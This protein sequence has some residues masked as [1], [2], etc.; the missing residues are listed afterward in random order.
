MLMNIATFIS[1]LIIVE[2]DGNVNAVGDD[3]DNIGCLQIHHNVVEDVNNIFG[4]DFTLDD[5]YDMQMS[6]V[7]CNLYLSYWGAKYEEN[8]GFT[9][10]PEV[11]AR[12]WN[13]GP[14]G[15]NKVSTKKY[16]LKV[17]DVLKSM[18]R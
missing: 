6:R 8:T 18:E 15:W 13:G 10:T 12:I 5:R 16:W 17:E 1:A 3:G 4:T 2:S 14:Q 11:Y 9:V 7:I